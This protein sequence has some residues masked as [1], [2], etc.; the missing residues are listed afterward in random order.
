[1]QISESNKSLNT[2]LQ[3]KVQKTLERMVGLLLEKKPDDPVRITHLPNML[4]SLYDL[5]SSR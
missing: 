3:V 1:M 4:D 5:I 2:E